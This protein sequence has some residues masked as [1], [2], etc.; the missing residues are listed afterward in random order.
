[1]VFGTFGEM[2]SNVRDF[3]D[4]AVDYGVYVTLVVHVYAA[5]QTNCVWSF[6]I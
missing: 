1:M 3:T 6:F 4:L 2:S 5:H